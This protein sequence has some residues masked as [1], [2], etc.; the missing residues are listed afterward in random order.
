MK[1][2]Y[3]AI[4]IYKLVTVCFKVVSIKSDLS[5]KLKFRSQHENCVSYYYGVIR[6]DFILVASKDM[7][8]NKEQ[9]YYKIA[10]VK[11]QNINQKIEWG[12]GSI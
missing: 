8:I 10:S 6:C 1:R 3:L 7:L 9:L 2:Q 12:G 11:Q 4:E 5:K